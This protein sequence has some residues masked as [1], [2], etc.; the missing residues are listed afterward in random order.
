M[1][2]R[3]T[4]REIKGMLGITNSE[5]DAFIDFNLPAV[6]DYVERSCRKEFETIPA[7]LKRIIAQMLQ[8]H[9]LA[10]DY[11]GIKS[12]TYGSYSV[13]YNTDYPTHIMDSLV[14]YEDREAK[15]I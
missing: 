10:S 12:E 9:I 5:H 14:L 15:F 1:D 11:T 6:L 4:R 13:S 8:F 7:G 2:A 3:I